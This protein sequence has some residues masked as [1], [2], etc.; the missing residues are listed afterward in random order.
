MQL[1]IRIDDETGQ[2]LAGLRPVLRAKVVSTV[3]G[4]H[5]AG[6]D[7]ARLL[8]V[9]RELSHLGTLIN[10]SLRLSRGL[11]TDSAAVTQAAEV[12]NALTRK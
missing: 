10:Q 12:I 3:L 5:V 1:R 8:E 7:L 6:V 9:R 4:A 2:R 11:L